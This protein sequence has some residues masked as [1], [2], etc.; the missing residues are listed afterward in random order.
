VARTKGHG[1]APWTREETILA[2][3][4]LL[5]NGL[6]ALPVTHP[7]VIELSSILRSLPSNLERAR[8]P[9]FRNPTGVVFKLQ[10][11]INVATGKGLGNVSAMDR[12]IW[13]ELG[14]RK[15]KV[16]EIRNLILALAPE[17]SSS[18][19]DVDLSDEFPEGRI[20]TLIHKRR[21]REPK[22]RKKLLEARRRALTLSCDACGSLPALKDIAGD[23]SIFEA[24]HRF[25]L[26]ITGEVN[27][28]LQDIALLCANCHRL[29]HRMIAKR[30]RWVA[31][32]ELRDLLIR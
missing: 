12:I 11:L 19:T 17:T 21:E 16:R 14:Q 4:L 7:E 28:R 26:S 1:N 10:N 25:P 31:V 9:S 32:E 27:T 20:I 15:L 13:R 8:K 30:G 18:Y 23:A 24:H 22:V 5:S 29:L 6:E 3:D 2:L